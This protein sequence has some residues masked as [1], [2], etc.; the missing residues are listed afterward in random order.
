MTQE[1]ALNVYQKLNLARSKFHA[2]E[3]KKSGKFP[4]GRGN[5]F[6]LSDFLIP[7]LR[8]FEE[9]GLCAVISFTPD[10]ATMEINDVEGDG[11][12]LFTSPMG[13]ANLKGCHEVQNIGAVE[14]Y[15]R[16]YLWIAALEIVEHDAIEPTTGEGQSEGSAASP[17]P[18]WSEPDST[19]SG[20]SKLKG[21]LRR[22]DRELEGCGDSEMVYALTD[23]AEWQEFCKIAGKHAE[24]YLHGGEPAPPE[25][26]GLI[27]K[28]KRLIAEFDRKEA[29]EK[30][31][32][33]RT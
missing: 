9:V 22:L 11:R 5:Y 23:T 21:E 16:R 17:P 31:A 18:K 32:F 26:E 1:K 25:F 6:E 8:I 33:A 14:T 10:M 13:S 29:D 20:I 27:V 28:A 3:L 4:G 7:A 19:L 24:H 15:Q 30:A 12:I 2:L